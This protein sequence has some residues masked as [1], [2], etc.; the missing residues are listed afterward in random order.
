MKRLSRV[1]APLF[2]PTSGRVADLA[3]SDEMVRDD[4]FLYRGVAA[5]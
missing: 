5:P 2:R 3:H 1:F 4:D